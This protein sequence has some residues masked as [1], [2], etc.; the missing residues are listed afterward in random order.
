M[1]SRYTL[2]CRPVS[3]RPLFVVCNPV[4]EIPDVKKNSAVGF[5]PWN[6]ATRNHVLDSILAPAEVTR[7]LLNR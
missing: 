5:D 4:I 6:L 3:N 7:R 1:G 2:N